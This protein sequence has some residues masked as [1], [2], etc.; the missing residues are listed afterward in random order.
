[1]IFGASLVWTTFV[2][3]F[4][5]IFYNDHHYGSHPSFT[6]AIICV[7]PS[8]LFVASVRFWVVDDVRRVRSYF[9]SNFPFNLIYL[10][11]VSLQTSWRLAA[12]SAMIMISVVP[13]EGHKASLDLKQYALAI[14]MF[15][16]FA[17]WYIC[18]FFIHTSLRLYKL[19]YLILRT[20]ES[21][22]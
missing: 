21:Y 15:M 8:R 10:R 18:V 4:R 6:L 7:D 1:M 17:P 16:S 20:V 5:F 9:W 2:T 22:I 3:V 19:N 14:K 13:A 11:C 12:S